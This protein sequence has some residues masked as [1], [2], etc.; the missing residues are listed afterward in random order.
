M[1][2]IMS[3][4]VRQTSRVRAKFLHKMFKFQQ[5]VRMSPLN[6]HAQERTFYL[7]KKY[8]K[9]T[10]FLFWTYLIIT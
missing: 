8:K 4:L 6:A 1:V 10:Y 2:L 3:K 9:L 5:V 7:K